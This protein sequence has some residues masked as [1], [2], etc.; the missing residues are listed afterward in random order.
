MEAANQIV[1]GDNELGC[2]NLP[3][4]L[5]LAEIHKNL[6]ADSF[7]FQK[8]NGFWAN[9]IQKAPPLFSMVSTSTLSPAAT[10]SG[11]TETDVRLVSASISQS[12][13]GSCLLRPALFARVQA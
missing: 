13:G 8:L 6:R 2:I 1:S 3:Q 4:R 12:V 5:H 11:Q 10:R 9:A 7:V